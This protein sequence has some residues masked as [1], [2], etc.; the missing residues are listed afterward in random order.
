M[1][2]KGERDMTKDMTAGKPMGL[3]W[4]FS[5]PLIFGNLFQQ[6][7]NMIDTIIVG[8][9]LGLSALTSVGATASIMF[10]I[11]GF[12]LGTCTGVGVPVA[13]KFGAKDYVNMRKYIMNAVYFSIFMA[14]V[15]TVITCLLC[16]NILTWMST[17][18]DIYQGAYEYL[19]VI[20]LGIPF[21][22]LYNVEAAV[23]RAMGDS[24]T[25][26]YYLILSTVLNIVLDLVF[27][28]VLQLGVRGAA[29]ATI[30]AQ[31]VAGVL[32]LLFMRGRYDVL[33]FQQDEKR[34]EMSCVKNIVV[35]S[36][37]M[38]LQF[39]ITAIGSIMLQSAVN[40]LGSVYV[41]AFTAAFKVK[42]LAMCPYEAFATAAA[43][44][45]SQNLGA[46]QFK[47]IRQGLRC[48]IL[49]A[50]IYGVAIGAVLIFAGS[51]IA[52]LY[53][54]ASETV[55]LAYAQ[56][57]LTIA[58]LFFWLLAFLNCTRLTIQGL[59][60]SGIAMFAGCSELVARGVMSLAIIPMF[61]FR[62]VCCTDPLAWLAANLV[63][64][65]VFFVI[66][67]R[68]ERNRK[69]EDIPV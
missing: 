24:K 9:Y 35:M 57:I 63:V 38:G 51:K 40:V 14:A 53:V 1:V 17:P 28:I 36:V 49:I 44:F 39:S 5:V 60:Y 2:V 6:M 34:L 33:V 7:Y 27:I 41:S 23:I 13:Q 52:L 21:T 19:F 45:G 25:P 12:C 26:F 20:F 16:D 66:I 32:C 61:H 64:I 4:Q 43:T 47:R 15:L 31:A 8:R 37:P 18:E 22:I 69:V 65:P 42:Q 67:R 58:G 48:G 54:D 30:L 50:F 55:V 46:G 59:G 3:I 11:I 68:L 29:L 62:A 56:Q 10:L